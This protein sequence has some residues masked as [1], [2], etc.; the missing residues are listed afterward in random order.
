M[1]APATITAVLGTSVKMD[2][3][4]L[5]NVRTDPLLNPTCLSDH[6]HTFYGAKAS[7]RPETTY[8]EMRATTENSGNVE[9]NKSLYWPGR[10]RT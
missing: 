9:E 3:L 2:F 10:L 8:E 5:A 4:P 7:L 1:L 6:V